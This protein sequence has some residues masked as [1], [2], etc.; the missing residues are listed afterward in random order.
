MNCYR[1]SRPRMLRRVSLFW[2]KS[3]R[4]E[5]FFSGGIARIMHDWPERKIPFT[6]DS[7]AGMRD[8]FRALAY[9]DDVHAVVILQIRCRPGTAY[10]VAEE[11]TL[12]EI[13]SELYS[14]SGDFDLLMKL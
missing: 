5:T 6:F 10:Q 2:T 4:Q 12:R 11:I 14:N 13:H 1:A 8:W 7:C 9:A 3:F